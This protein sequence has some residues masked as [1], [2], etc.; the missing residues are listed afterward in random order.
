[1]TIDLEIPDHSV[2][3]ES[4]ERRPGDR[5]HA[6]GPGV[7]NVWA[8][9]WRTSQHRPRE[10]WV[11]WLLFVVFFTMPAV[12]GFLL[13]RG[14]AAL[15]SGDTTATV[16]WAGGIAVSE[17]IRMTAVHHGALI[18][19]KAWIHMQTLLR[20]N[21]LSAQM[22]SGGIHAGQPVGSAGSAITHFRDDTEDVANFVDGMVDVSGGLVF[23]LVAGIALG[24]ADARAAAVLALPLIGVAVATRVLDTR[25]KEYRAADRAATE[26]VTGLLGDVM[27]A[28][29]TVKVN[30]AADP[31]LRRLAVLVER[32]R[33]TAVRDRVLE[34]GVNAFGQG[35]ADIGLGLVLL[36][37]AGAIASGSFDLGTL[38]LFT[39]YLG[40]LSFLPK[41][42]GRVLARR[43]QA[44][45]AF[46]RMRMLVAGES[47]RNTVRDRDLPIDPGDGAVRPIGVRPERVPLEVFEVRDLSVSFGEHPVVSNFSITVRRGDFVVITGAVGS[48]K[49]TL[50]RAILGLAWQ[51]EVSGSVRWNG[52][53]ID[54]R[55]AFLVPPN[56]AF[57]SQVPQ[58][59]SD[60]VADNIALGETTSA[61][62]ATAL[63]LAAVDTDIDEMADGIDTMI[64][65]RGLRL[66]GGQRQRLATAR[67]L[68]HEPELVVLDDLSSALDVETEVRLW[69]NLADAGMTVIA[70]SHRAVAFERADQILRL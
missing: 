61:R 33:R 12:T 69:S 41:M 14:Y 67:A 19:T 31:L 54:D 58:L 21:M 47:A 52:E 43:K 9:A 22:A 48:G 7:P 62:L 32:R 63:R 28:A 24:T 17:T 29:T 36:V 30:D 68:V 27:A 35:A 37:S 40:W 66:S 44:G 3:A 1:M 57:L 2:R 20:A 16:W 59:I 50:L 10:F 15:E 65:P 60:S 18:W 26:E 38:A 13:A 46:D 39:A 6:T 53:E 51:A 4:N 64:G 23:T 56:A 45:V 49:S 70:V 55:S 11:G 42:V 5:P 25:I 34:E 8:L